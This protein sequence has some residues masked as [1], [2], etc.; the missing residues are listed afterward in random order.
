MNKPK[1]SKKTFALPEDFA[2]MA[3]EI[4]GWTFFLVMLGELAWSD[5]DKKRILRF[6]GKSD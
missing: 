4:A 1:K 5:A 2:Q 3:S 6:Y